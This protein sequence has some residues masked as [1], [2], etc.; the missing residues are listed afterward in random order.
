MQGLVDDRLDLP[1]EIVMKG[2]G[3]GDIHRIQIEGTVVED[4][5]TNHHRDLL[6]RHGLQAFID[7]LVDFGIVDPV[8]QLI[9]VSEMIIKAF[10]IQ[11]ALRANLS[12]G[13]LCQRFARHAL[14]ER[15]RQGS[16]RNR[17]V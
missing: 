1:A 14:L 5:A 17:G 11:A 16:L 4:G 12:N 2:K 13:N 10:P 8:D 7:L 3:T 9:L 15:T 6:G